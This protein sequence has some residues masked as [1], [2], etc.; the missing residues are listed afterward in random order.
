MRARYDRPLAGS[1]KGCGT[2]ASPHT[3]Y[4]DLGTIYPMLTL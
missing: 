4:Q 2:I 3:Q 1:V